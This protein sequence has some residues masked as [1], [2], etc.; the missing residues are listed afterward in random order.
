[1]RGDEIGKEGE[2]SQQAPKRHFKFGRSETRDKLEGGTQTNMETADALF[3]NSRQDGNA[4]KIFLLLLVGNVDLN[5]DFFLNGRSSNL[6][7]FKSKK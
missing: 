1:M 5:G 6:E 7:F 4:R 3:T 2:V